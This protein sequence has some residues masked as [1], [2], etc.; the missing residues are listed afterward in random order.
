MHIKYIQQFEPYTSKHNNIYK[1]TDGDNVST[2]KQ[3]NA[4]SRRCST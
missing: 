1:I 3:I 4:E 2:N